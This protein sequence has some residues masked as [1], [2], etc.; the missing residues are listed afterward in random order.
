MNV[1][2]SYFRAD[3][4]VLNHP[5]DQVVRGAAFCQQAPEL[6]TKFVKGVD[7]LHVADPGANGD[8]NGFAGNLAGNS[9]GIADEQRRFYRYRYCC[10]RFTVFSR[11][12]RVS[13]GEKVHCSKSVQGVG[14]GLRAPVVGFRT[15]SLPLGDWRHKPTEISPAFSRVYACGWGSSVAQPFEF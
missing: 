2:G 5:I 10:H 3:V 11:E 14:K 9:G 13:S 8:D 12:T 1:A 4:E 6:S 15:R 7:R